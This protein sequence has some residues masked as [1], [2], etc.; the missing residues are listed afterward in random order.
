SGTNNLI[1]AYGLADPSPSGPNGEISYHENRRGSRTLP[2]RSYA[3]PPSEETFAGLDYF[4]FR[5][6]NVC[7][8]S[9]SY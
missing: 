6:N 2:L 4:E 1:F 7:H 9:M 3:D 8:I 5:L